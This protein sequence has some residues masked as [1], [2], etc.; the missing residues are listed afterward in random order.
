MSQADPNGMEL[1]SPPIRVR[2]G[3]HR[4][5]AAFVKTFE[6]PVN[7][8]IAPIGH[9]IADTQIGADGGITI[10]PHLRELVV[11]GPYHPTGVSD[12]P[13]RKRIFS[14]RPLSAAEARPCAQKILT[15]LG[16]VAYRRPLAASDV[17]GVL[18]FYDEGAKESGFEGGVRFALEALLSSPHFIFRVEE[19]PATAKPGD[20]LPSPTSTWRRAS[21]SSCGGRPPMRR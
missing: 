8:L 7:D 18:K 10:L 21:R 6:G 1:K 16:S 9:S 15:S 3:P 17:Q 14:C 4:I 2:A 12:T 20:R 13:S 11:L 19:K 5:S